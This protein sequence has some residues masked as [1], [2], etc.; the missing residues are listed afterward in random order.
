MQRFC[1]A[2]RMAKEAWVDIESII[3]HRAPFRLLDEYLEASPKRVLARAV[4]RPDNVFFDAALGGV[5]TWVGVEYM[6]QAA[7]IWV[8]LCD[9]TPDKPAEP[10]FLISSRQLDANESVFA[11]GSELLVRIDVH[12]TDGPIVAF[13]GSI[14]Q[15]GQGQERLL[16]E[17]EFSAFRP[18]DLAGYIQSSDPELVAGTKEA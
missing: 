10:A 9:S 15:T 1:W 16:C 8:G 17:G 12:F 4:I 13:H 5:P 14:F 2:P 6:A 7:A 11:E 18:D 3:P